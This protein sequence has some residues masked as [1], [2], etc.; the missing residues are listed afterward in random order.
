[1]ISLAY[2]D[3]L[4]VA[5]GEQDHQALEDVMKKFNGNYI[6]AVE[7]SPCLGADGMFCLPGGK[8]FLEK[9][10][11]VAKGAKAVIAW[12]PALPGAAS[13]PPNRIRQNLFLLQMSSKISRLSAYRAA[14]RSRKS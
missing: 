4:M 10:M 2:D 6:L 1:M 14:P 9:L 3:T 5:A 13:T 7:G 8:P 12:A 11:H